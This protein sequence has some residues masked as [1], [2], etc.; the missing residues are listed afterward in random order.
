MKKAPWILAALCVALIAL[1]FI[2]H[3]ALYS[4]VKNF[5]IVSDEPTPA[6]VIIVLGGGCTNR[7]DYGVSLYKSEYADTL[8]LS[9]GYTSGGISESEAMKARALSLGVPDNALLTENRS[10][11]T[12]ENARYSLEIVKEQKFTSALI[13]TSPY[14]TRRTGII[15]NQVFKGIDITICS[16]Q[17]SPSNTN[18]NWED[19]Y[20]PQQIAL[21]YLKIGGYYLHIR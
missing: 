12:F 9:G 19:D 2:Q 20:S 14:H 18:E 17:N 6:D 10:L 13:V 11:S 16:F 3:N 15:F 7:I 4:S 21:E 8:L 5:L 1:L